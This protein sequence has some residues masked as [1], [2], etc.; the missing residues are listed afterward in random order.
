MIRVFFASYSLLLVFTIAA[1]IVVTALENPP[2]SFLI[3]AHRGASAVAPEN[4]IIAFK[5]AMELHANAIE[6]DVRQT[7]DN[8]LVVLHDATVNRTTNGRGGIATMTLAEVRKLDAGSWFDPHFKNERIPTFHEVIEILDTAT[9]LIIEIKEGNETYPGIE[10]QV[11]NLVKTNRLEG[12]VILKSFDQRVLRRIKEKA[13]QIRLLYVYVFTIPWLNITVDRGVSAGDL[14]DLNVDYL[15]PH[16]IFLSRS[17]VNRAQERG[18]KV[19]V[20]DVEDEDTMKEMLDLGVNGIETDF[21]D[22]L[23]NVLHERE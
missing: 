13:P 16:K 2:R 18:F 1:P 23:Y 14:L 17:F 8:Q 20:W 4:T 11:L 7:K 15:Q 21:P 22:K 12:Q 10:E 3:I 9:I 19:I 5:K 6:L